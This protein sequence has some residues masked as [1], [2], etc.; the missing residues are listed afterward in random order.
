MDP[1]KVSPQKPLS[2]NMELQIALTNTLLISIRCLVEL[3]LGAAVSFTIC[4]GTG[5]R[6]SMAREHHSL[7]KTGRAQCSLMLTGDEKQTNEGPEA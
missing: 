1:G 4:V 2:M 7:F 3:Q 5:N 6:S